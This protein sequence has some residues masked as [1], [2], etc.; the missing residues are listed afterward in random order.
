MIKA[1]AVPALFSAAVAVFA[2]TWYTEPAKPMAAFAPQ[3]SLE[4]ASNKPAFAAHLASSNMEDF[5]HSASVSGLGGGDLM[6]VW[7]AGTREG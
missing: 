5:V 6:A 3:G 4:N 2:F 1:F 7:F